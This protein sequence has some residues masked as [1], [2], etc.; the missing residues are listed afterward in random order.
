MT[1]KS[2]VVVIGA[3]WAGLAT[4][5]KLTKHGFKVS[6][7]ESAKQ[8]GGRARS[9]SVNDLNVDNGQHLLIGAGFLIVSV[10]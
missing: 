3:G 8:A 5:V 9:V 7:F 6:L 2:D 1:K 4:A 10:L